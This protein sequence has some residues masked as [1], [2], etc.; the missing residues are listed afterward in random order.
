[1]RAGGE[2]SGLS[3]PEG[4]GKILQ[5]QRGFKLPEEGA[6]DLKLDIFWKVTDCHIHFLILVSGPALDCIDTRYLL[7]NVGQVSSIS[8][9]APR[10]VV[11][12]HRH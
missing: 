7:L 1:M 8:L 5:G 4:L 2:A 10:V 12:D 9:S 11:Q 6:K 3:L